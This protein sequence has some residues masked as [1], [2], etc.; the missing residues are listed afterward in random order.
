VSETTASDQDEAAPPRAKDLVGQVIS[1]RYRIDALLAT[2]GMG[3]VYK[4]YHLLLKKR[5]AIK[6]L[7]PEMENLPELV[8][9]FE[10]E[11]IAGAHVAHPN[12]AAATDFGQLEDGS[13]FLVLEYVSGE[14]LDAAVKR[15]P[16]PPARAVR[17]ARQL[18]SALAA[19]H[20]MDIV[21]RDL[22]PRNVMLVAGREEVAKL[23]DFGLAKVPVERVVRARRA[24]S[25]G[26]PRSKRPR[27]DSIEDSKPRL[28]G[29]GVILG[30]I[31]YLAPEAALG[32][33]AV[34]AR[35]D[36]YALGVVLYEMLAGKR[37]F[38]ATDDVTLFAQHRF[39]K[40]PPFAVRAPGVAV[41]PALEAIVMRLLAKEPADRF[42]TGVHVIDALD[43]LGDELQAASAP[44]GR[45]PVTSPP[46]APSRIASVVAIGAVV[47]GLAAALSLFHATRQAASDTTAA[48]PPSAAPTTSATPEP[49]AE[50]AAAPAAS[51]AATAEP[52]ATA[53]A[54]PAAPAEQGDPVAARASL[55]RALR[56]RDW[57]GGEA[58]FF[59]LL[60]RDPRAFHAPEMGQAARDLAVALEREHRGDPIFAALT[61]KLGPDGLDILFDLVAST[62]RSNAALRAA[63][64]L[65]RQEVIAR[66]TPEMRI[67]FELREAPCVDKLAL[68]DR[69]VKE[70]D[71]RALIVLENQGMAC[72]RKNNKAVAE[73]MK[74]LRARLRRKP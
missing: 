27:L 3:A 72:F 64:V 21:H 49:K 56:V 34:D 22:K 69:T 35:A 42:A 63:E 19:A 8:G 4:G 73:A 67:A 6:I 36:L 14:T 68:L 33:D 5:V 12:V 20:A 43:A 10:R 29:V 25:V 23:I 9:R 61:D 70:G 7:H 32:M 45:E 54:E 41:P 31:A 55:L 2:G 58:A 60:S 28:T 16:M 51:T 46:R 62:G 1:Q 39:Q 13:Y 37:P 11:A 40:P 48:P 59:D 50:A 38:D 71:A 66:A 24:D 65:R 44:R 17:I 57:S 74:E 18:A 47:L 52:A 30:T 53:S 26:A 15:G